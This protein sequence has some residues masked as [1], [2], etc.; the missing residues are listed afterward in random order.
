MKWS[1]HRVGRAAEREGGRGQGGRVTKPGRR[2]GERGGREREG[3]GK[4]E[5]KRGRPGEEGEGRTLGEKEAGREAKAR[6][7]GGRR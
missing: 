7:E 6:G 2:E 5:G 4:G 3:E 1:N